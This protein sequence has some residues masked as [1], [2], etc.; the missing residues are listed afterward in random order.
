MAR[1]RILLVCVLLLVTLTFANHFHNSFH[2]DDAH[3]IVENP[4]IRDL[5][6]V[7]RFFTD[8]AMFSVLPTNRSWRPLVSTSLAIDY[9]L[10]HGYNPIWFHI[11]TWLWFL[12]QLGAMLALYR[13]I[14]AKIR[15]DLE[16]VALAAVAWYGVHPAIAETINYIIQRGDLYCTLGVVSGIAIYARVPRLRKYGVYLIP[17]VAANLS[18]PTALI[19]P[20]LLFAYVFLI[21]NDARRDRIGASLRAGIPSGMVCACMA[22]LD[23]A[24]T[25]ATYLPSMIPAYDYRITQ[26]FVWLRC[27]AAFFLP[28]HLSADSD[29]QPFT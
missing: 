29:L 21:E 3:T 28:I 24:M 26:P 4:A 17:V 27:F 23:K 1:S 15:P 18:K 13:H 9:A 25:P 11:S 7:P 6:N 19:F 22:W 12:V 8:A 2:F 5:R 10:A 16:W 20:A 14:A